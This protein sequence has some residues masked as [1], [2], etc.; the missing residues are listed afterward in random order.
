MYGSFETF[1]ANLREAVEEA[2][3][4]PPPTP[5]SRLKVFTRSLDTPN[6]AGVCVLVVSGPDALHGEWIERAIRENTGIENM[7]DVEIG[8]PKIPPKSIQ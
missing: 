3:D 8:E 5:G 4:C 6:G 2:L 7:K 1:M